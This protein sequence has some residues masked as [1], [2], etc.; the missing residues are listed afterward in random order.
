MTVQN[1]STGMIINGKTVEA[2]DKEVFEV[3]NPANNQ[4]V[5]VVP[6]GGKEDAEKAVN[7]AHG[8]FPA[9]KRKTAGE[10]SALIQKW[11]DLLL[12][13][14]EEMAKILVAEA[15]KTINDARGEVDYA[16]SFLSWF[17]EEGKRVYGETIPASTTDK[18]ILVINEPIGVVGVITPWNFPAASITKKI[19]AALAVGCPV[20]IKPSEYTPIAALKLAELAIEAGIPKGVVNVVMGRANEIGEVFLQDPR[21]KMISFT[22]STKVGKILMRGA[23]D[24]VTKLS[25]ELGGNAPAIVFDDADLDRAVESVMA[26][27]FR[28]S[29]QT[30]VCANRIFVQESIADQFLEKMIDQVSKLKVGTSED[31][32]A[33][34]GPLINEDA[35]AKIQKHIQDAVSKGATLEYGGDRIEEY[36]NGYFVT[37]C[38]ISGVN[39]EMEVWNEETF[40]PLAPIITFKDEE[41]AVERANNTPYGLASYAFTE[42]LS[43][44]VRLYEKL[45]TGIVGINDGLPAAAQAPFGGRKESGI[46]LE[47]GHYGLEEFLETKYVSIKLHE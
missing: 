37:P 16:A 27:K 19:G 15:G 10:R 21:I 20:V 38:I 46:G 43:R 2:A 34:L 14:K 6:N 47:G 18:R 12:D 7:A 31:P 9:W 41:E 32:D 1:I 17:A 24:T 45:D 40:G 33:D 4:I 42:N 44:A 3:L 11:H 5:G 26:T 22:G 8:A 39:E 25:L 30:C 35:Y 36:E 28:N 13:R 23:A 29:G